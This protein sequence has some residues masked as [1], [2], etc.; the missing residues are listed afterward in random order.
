MIGTDKELFLAI[1]FKTYKELDEKQIE[2]IFSN[3]YDN[4]YDETKH[5]VAKVALGVLEIEKIKKGETLWGI[6]DKYYVDSTNPEFEIGHCIDHG[7]AKE[8]DRKTYIKCLVVNNPG[9]GEI[10]GYYTG[11]DKNGNPIQ[12]K[13]E[14]MV[15]RNQILNEKN[16]CL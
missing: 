1:I 15:K 2:I 6:Y 5:L 16:S 13:R 11:C 3:M 14:V 8:V 12:L 9:Y 7:F 10:R 4:I